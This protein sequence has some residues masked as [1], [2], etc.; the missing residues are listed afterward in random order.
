MKDVTIEYMEAKNYPKTTSNLGPYLY[1][2]LSFLNS[3]LNEEKPYPGLEIGYKA[4]NIIELAY[5]SSK[6]NTIINFN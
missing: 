4:H 1:E 6:K 5:Q 3:V 2:N